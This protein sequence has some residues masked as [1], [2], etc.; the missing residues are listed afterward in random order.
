MKKK[1]LATGLA[2]VVAMSM[3]AGCGASDNTAAADNTTQST[4][5]T[6]ETTDTTEETTESASEGGE[7]ISIYVYG[8]DQEQAMYKELF[9][10]FEAQNNCTV[11][12]QFSIKDDYGTT[13]T[14][15]MTAK[16]LPDVFYMGPE[17][18]KPYVENGY[19]LDMKPILEAEGLDT[20]DVL[21]GTMDAY[22]Y[23]GGQYGLPH[24]SSVFAYAYNKDLFDAAGLEYP[25]P[26]KP[27]TYEEFVEVC[28]ALTK[29][30]DGDGEVDQWGCAFWPNLMIQPWLYTNGTSFLTDDYKAVNVEDPK[31]VEAMDKMVA[32]TTELGVTPTVEQEQGTGVYQ[33]WIDGTIGFYA[34]GTWDIAAFMDP[35][36]VN[37]GWDLCA[38]P[39]LSTGETY[40]W[41]GT[42]GY[43]VNA[44][45]ENDVLA[46]KLAYYMSAS[47]EAMRLESGIEGGNSILI[48]NLVSMADGEFA[49]A[50]KAG[51]LKYP[52]NY[53]VLF[54]YLNNQNGYKS[55]FNDETFT[56]N[57][58]WLNLFFEGIDQV[59]SGQMT[60]ADFCSDIAPQM[61]ELLDEAYAN[62]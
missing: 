58:E 21:A 44:A 42:V 11:D 5:T 31:F 15:M 6:A 26:D 45:T 51:T 40:A 22:E 46:T 34:C 39:T 27:Y 16:N 29:D 14:G 62:E 43:C 3:L 17:N 47:P 57:A 53:A 20:S 50:I 33:R 48:P 2:A 24:D 60:T 19:V 41:C 38:Y 8:N 55:R 61:Q 25:N 10:K 54:N 59:R 36:V 37:F 7:T 52:N 30:T 9:A 1:L 18:V 49:E 35:E 28:K 13:I 12:A 56:P 32:L 23:E 4:E